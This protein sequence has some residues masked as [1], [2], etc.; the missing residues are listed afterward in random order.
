MEQEE[1]LTLENA[2]KIQKEE[3]IIWALKLGAECYCALEDYTIK[4]NM[5]TLDPSCIV[6]RDAMI[7]FIVNYKP[8]RDSHFEIENEPKSKFKQIPLF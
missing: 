2:I 8:S 6:T 4:K 7:D 5:E 3:L 1:Q